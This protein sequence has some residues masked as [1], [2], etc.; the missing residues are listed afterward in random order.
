MTEA[1]KQVRQ[2]ADK[3]IVR[4]KE[5]MRSTIKQR[6]ARNNRTMNAEIVFLIEKG[7]EVTYGEK[8][9]G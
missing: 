3:Y 5:G 2:P 6:A 4:F 1:K 8:N 7:M 9:H